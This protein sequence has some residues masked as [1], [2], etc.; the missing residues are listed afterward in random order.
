MSKSRR[1]FLKLTSAAGIA[2]AAPQHPGTPTHAGAIRAMDSPEG[3]V[4]VTPAG[5]TAAA[6]GTWTVTVEVS[7]GGQTLAS[8]R[9]SLNAK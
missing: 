6:F 5:G 9:T 7:R 8:Y 4:S 1:D 2:A 3:S